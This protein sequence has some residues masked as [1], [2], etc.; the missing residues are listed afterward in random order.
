[1]DMRLLPDEQYRRA[2]R[3]VC[4]LEI[5]GRFQSWLKEKLNI[6]REQKIKEIFPYIIPNAFFHLQGRLWWTSD[7]GIWQKDPDEDTSTETLT[8]YV[9]IQRKREADRD[10]S[11]TW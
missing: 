8:S 11:H 3:R 5:E 10:L 2:N 4:D 9:Y 6:Q 7:K 1:M